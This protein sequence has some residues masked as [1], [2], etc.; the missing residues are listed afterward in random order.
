MSE[1][2]RR[3]KKTSPRQEQR[4]KRAR[5]GAALTIGSSLL[6]AA[7]PLGEQ[8]FKVPGKVARAATRVAGE[9]LEEVEEEIERQE[10]ERE[11][12][13]QEQPEEQPR[14]EERHEEEQRQEE[15]EQP[16]EE[17]EDRQREEEE[18][19]RR[20]E[21][22]Q[23]RRGEEQERRER[24][25][26]Q[27]EQERERQREEQ[28]ERERQE[29]QERAEQQRQ[30][31]ERRQQEQRSRQ[32]ELRRQ[33]EQRRR[34]EDERRRRQQAPQA[35]AQ[36][37]PAAATSY[38][39]FISKYFYNQRARVGNEYRDVIQSKIL[40][41]D[42]LARV[43]GIP[44]ELATDYVTRMQQTNLQIAQDTGRPASLEEILAAAKSSPRVTP[45]TAR[46]QVEVLRAAVQPVGAASLNNLREGESYRIAVNLPDGP[47]ANQTVNLTWQMPDGKPLSFPASLDLQGAVEY[48][49]SPATP[50]GEYVLQEVKFGALSATPNARV[51]VA[52][53]K[54]T[55]PLI[56]SVAVLPVANANGSLPNLLRLRNSDKYKIKV[57]G[58]PESA[59]IKTSWQIFDAEHPNG[60][61]ETYSFALDDAGEVEFEISDATAKGDYILQ[62]VSYKDE[63]FK[64]SPEPKLTVL[65]GPQ[66][67][68]GSTRRITTYLVINPNVLT[69]QEQIVN[70]LAG[71]LLQNGKPVYVG[72]GRILVPNVFIIT[73]L[74]NEFNLF[75]I[76]IPAG[77]LGGFYIPTDGLQDILDY[78][79][80]LTPAN[81]GALA[82]LWL[83][84]GLLLHK[85]GEWTASAEAKKFGLAVWTPETMAHESIHQLHDIDD[86]FLKNWLDFWNS[87]SFINQ[88]KV[89]LAI[90]SIGAYE[91]AR[92]TALILSESMARLGTAAGDE[93]FLARFKEASGDLGKM[94]TEY[95]TAIVPQEDS[96]IPKKVNLFTVEYSPETDIFTITLLDEDGGVVGT[97]EFDSEDLSTVFDRAVEIIGTFATDG[98]YDSAI[99]KLNRL[100]LRRGG[101][102]LNFNGVVLLNNG[103]VFNVI[104]GDPT[105]TLRS[106]LNDLIAQNGIAGLF[107][108]AGR[109]GEMRL[110]GVVE[111]ASRLTFG[112]DSVETGSRQYFYSNG[113]VRLLVYFDP[114]GN[115]LGAASPYQ[116]YGIQ[117]RPAGIPKEAVPLPDGKWVVVEL[118]PR[119]SVKITVY[120]SE[121]KI[122][123]EDNRP[124]GVPA[125]AKWTGN[126]WMFSYRDNSSGTNVQMLWDPS[127][128]NPTY[129]LINGEVT[130]LKVKLDWTGAV[131]GIELIGRN[132]WP[133]GYNPFSADHNYI[134]LGEPG[135]GGNNRGPFGGLVQTNDGLWH[136]AGTII[137]WPDGSWSP[138]K[139]DLDIS[140]KTIA[141]QT[142]TLSEV[143]VTSAGDLLNLRPG[144][145]YKIQALGT[146]GA[147][148]GEKLT[149]IWDTPKEKDVKYEWTLDQNGEVEFEIS[150]A[151]PPGEYYFKSATFKDSRVDVKQR[152]VVAARQRVVR[153]ITPAEVLPGDTVTVQGEG[154][155]EVKQVEIYKTEPVYSGLIPAALI[156]VSEREVKFKAP[157][158]ESGNYKVS[159]KVS[160]TEG[161]GFSNVTFKI[162]PSS[163]PSNVIQTVTLIPVGDAKL[164]ALKVG[165]K[166]R[167]KATGTQGPL[168]NAKLVTVWNTPERNDVKYEWD[169]D[170][171][172]EIEFVISKETKPGQ[173]TLATASFEGKEVWLYQSVVVT[174]RDEDIELVAFGVRSDS[175]YSWS[176]D[177]NKIYFGAYDHATKAPLPG[178][179]KLIFR[180]YFANEEVEAVVDSINP[181]EVKIDR[182]LRSRKFGEVPGN[183]FVTKAVR[184]GDGR[185]FKAYS[186]T[187]SGTLVVVPQNPELAKPTQ[188]QIESPESGFVTDGANIKVSGWV[189]YDPLYP[190][191][192]LFLRIDGK[193]HFLG[194]GTE[195]DRPDLASR[196][197]GMKVK[198]FTLEMPLDLTKEGKHVLD[199]EVGHFYTEQDRNV[200]GN[201][202][203]FEIKKSLSAPVL[204]K[205]TKNDAVVTEAGAGEVITIHGRNLNKDFDPNLPNGAF[206]QV[207]ITPHP[208]RTLILDYVAGQSSD[209]KTIQI[210]LSEKLSGQAYLRVQNQNGTSNTLPLFIRSIKAPRITAVADGVFAMEAN[211]LVTSQRYLDHNY[212]ARVFQQAIQDKTDF[213][214]LVPSAGLQKVFEQTDGF[215]AYGNFQFYANANIPG[216][217]SHPAPAPMRLQA[218]VQVTPPKRGEINSTVL[219]E[220]GHRWGVFFRFPFQEVTNPAGPHW[221]PWYSH[222]SAMSYSSV[223]WTDNKDGTFTA[224]ESL[225]DLMKFN[226]SDMYAMGL[227]A[228]VEVRPSFAIRDARR[229]P[230]STENK[231]TGKRLDL[232]I[233]DIIGLNGPR[234][235]GPDRSPKE[236]TVAFLYLKLPNEDVKTEQE[237]ILKAVGK[238]DSTWQQA[239][240]GKSRMKLLEKGA[241]Q[242]LS[243][244]QFEVLD[245]EARSFHYEQTEEVKEVMEHAREEFERGNRRADLAEVM[246]MVPQATVEETPPPVSIPEPISAPPVKEEP[247]V[248]IPEMPTPEAKPPRYIGPPI[249]ESPREEPPRE[250]PP[251]TIMPAPLP[252]TRPTEPLVSIPEN[253]LAPIPVEPE[254]PGPKPVMPPNFETQPGPRA[255]EAPAIGV[256]LDAATPL[257]VSAGKRDAS[258]LRLKISN[259]SAETV[260]ISTLKFNLNR[261][262]ALSDL[263]LYD[264]GTL[265]AGP[266]N[267]HI[268]T[269]DFQTSFTVPAG[270]SK[271][272]EIRGDV[273]ADSGV[274]RLSMDPGQIAGY[275]AE[276]NA[277][278]DLSGFSGWMQDLQIVSA[279]LSAVAVAL[280]NP[281]LATGPGQTLAKMKVTAENTDVKLTSA[282]FQISGPEA[283]LI[284]NDIELVHPA[285]GIILGHAL[286]DSTG[287]VVMAG[288]D[289][290]IAGGTFEAYDLRT[291]LVRGTGSAYQIKLARLDG[292]D[293]GTGSH[294]AHGEITL[295]EVLTPP[296]VAAPRAVVTLDAATPPSVQAQAREGS[297]LW[298][299]VDNMS[300]ED[301]SLTGFKF[302]LEDPRM[303]VNV[304]LFERGTLVAGPVERAGSMTFNIPSLVP[305]RSSKTYQIRGDVMAY[306]AGS[307][308]F[309]LEQD[310][311]T[312]SGVVSGKPVDMSDSRGFTHTLN[313]TPEPEPQ[314]TP[315]PIPVPLPTEP[316]VGIPE[317]PPIQKIGPPVVAAL[318]AAT[319]LSVTAGDTS[320]PLFAFKISNGGREDVLLTG[321]NLSVNR[322][323]ALGNIQLF[324][325]GTPVAGQNDSLRDTV[326][327]GSSK[328]YQ[329]RGDVLADSGSVTFALEGIAGS[330]S[331][332]GRDIDASAFARFAQSV[333]ITPRPAPPVPVT[334][335]QPLPVETPAPVPEQPKAEPE[336]PTAHVVAQEAPAVLAAFPTGF[337]A[338]AG[339][340]NSRGYKFIPANSTNQQTTLDYISQ[341][342]LAENTEIFTNY[343]AQNG[344][345]IVNKVE[346][347]NLVFLYATK[348]NNDLSLKMDE[349]GGIVTVSATYLTRR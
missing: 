342:S 348:D 86:E 295:G 221:G 122:N 278:V 90:K 117:N 195:K 270:S 322:P 271:A 108:N 191:S 327:M 182:T 188:Y 78:L 109:G 154:L 65:G 312:G 98:D 120:D 8:I 273:F 38:E 319:P 83:E 243:V 185:E 14:E 285:T 87:L 67:P 290:V 233:E 113:I 323:E 12:E 260:I 138:Y 234:T 277:P 339:I 157:N 41:I 42:E 237:N 5:I 247:V 311:V 152:M 34:E 330:G 265:I 310:A 190:A 231:V 212:S 197:A 126:G 186:Q 160:D 293:L 257:S 172:G 328:T 71:L 170:K 334:Q 187:S 244:Q 184:V 181:I 324:S 47:V 253:P 213:I 239:T 173:Y 219:H 104:N 309:I 264:A 3:P 158:V 99:S 193:S 121:G 93:E 174:P 338:E 343:L 9:D 62:S 218:L 317:N 28:A 85:N 133:F 60:R 156:S 2:K 105:S 134:N 262:R 200:R 127:D 297:L 40:G 33:E 168:V 274:I 92:D 333:N 250:E 21:E 289:R 202:I 347:P 286:A 35:P 337:P 248:S 346:L 178:S 132:G 275:G 112:N 146:Q 18:R 340:E 215:G 210:K 288:L 145:K 45:T 245:A 196:F 130:Q 36:T 57:D 209:G 220:L 167:V 51:V 37:T 252:K 291:T 242:E 10:E 255:R 118:G 50:P 15:Q 308:T 279:K 296:A 283:G 300:N 292:V 269:V 303:L 77:G 222:V 148:A 171:N 214:A 318:D 336:T 4:Q 80:K 201:K 94:L 205:I 119:G 124:A 240:R 299:Q 203:E 123:P 43:A 268:T 163:T 224:R 259:L 136:G 284:F 139:K 82:N 159:L 140:K 230:G 316:P 81:A 102:P 320:V 95:F 75:G 349:Q 23:G 241:L 216:I 46:L 256:T 107:H 48:T 304:K 235:P 276:S 345:S 251:V 142:N 88:L 97:Y 101:L 116:V 249:A 226:D 301:I 207:I 29:R 266:V 315:P 258:V 280:A 96:P 272:V 76:K 314:P 211:D 39:D 147:L 169:L 223:N 91:G 281:N 228:P 24:E 128:G 1:I 66:G 72:Q 30:Q 31:E 254:P 70:Y 61:T 131:I 227:V 58:L 55:T 165:D 236:F 16:H 232:K 179:W 69:Q 238:L 52:S 68:G 141:P 162:L 267:A 166:Y 155:A 25:A 7:A 329:V 302:N 217:F 143:K 49:I 189:A 17:E 137:I 144:D 73:N 115:F 307:M 27:R 54:V 6:G 199:L 26:E 151:T 332:S 183:F 79:K 84:N 53:P 59:Q 110:I 325:G 261:P 331:V 344:F 125:A 298:F 63:T 225:E 177:G 321:L 326:P 175:N 150:S 19:R 198:Q 180:N 341:K 294:L 229:V 114:Q 246:A 194:G 161:F 263:K 89:F 44:R 335:P 282:I 111:V 153:S 306:G 204:E 56:K 32:E 192:A 287:R 313:I 100:F 22:E 11:E 64:L 305:A 206:Q 176:T 129:V 208:D 13:E 103:Q 20:E 164:Q 135:T 149:T 106:T 74:A